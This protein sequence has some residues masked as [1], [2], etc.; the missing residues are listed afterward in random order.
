[1]DTKGVSVTNKLLQSGK[2][3]GSVRMKLQRLGPQGT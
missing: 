1:M 2:A 3:D